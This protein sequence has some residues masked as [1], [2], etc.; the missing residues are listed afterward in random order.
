[1]KRHT[2]TSAILPDPE[3]HSLVQQYSADMQERMK[4][5]IGRLV[6]SLPTFCTLL[7]KGYSLHLRLIIGFICLIIGFI[8]LIITHCLGAKVCTC[9][10]C[11]DYMYMHM[12]VASHDFVYCYS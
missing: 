9:M 6:T 4:E 1:M 11:M 8:C 5:E 2:I 10:M 7:G 3:V 12:Y